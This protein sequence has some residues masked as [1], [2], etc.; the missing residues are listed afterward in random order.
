MKVL[1]MLRL[2]MYIDSKYY[3]HSLRGVRWT[4]GNHKFWLNLCR[5]IEDHGGENIKAPMLIHKFKHDEI[6][7]DLDLHKK[8]LNFN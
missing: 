8:N 4:N 1:H 5:F 3:K 6:R 7:W 2:V